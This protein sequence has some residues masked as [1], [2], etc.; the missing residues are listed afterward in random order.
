MIDLTL[1]FKLI[2]FS[3]IF[4]F[5]FSALL[6]EFNKIIKKSSTIIEIIF[7]FL[8]I[9]FMTIIYF[10]GIQKIGNAI[11]HIY[12]VLS[13]VLGFFLYDIILKLIANNKKKW[14]TL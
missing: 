6:E 1:Q 10:L 2:F 12:S 4:G 3:F 9:I 13:I 11:F 14:Y 7:S 5:M 8:F